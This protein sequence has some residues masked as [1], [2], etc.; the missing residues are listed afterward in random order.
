MMSETERNLCAVLYGKNDLRLVYSIASEITIR[1]IILF[2]FQEERKFLKKP[3]KGGVYYLSVNLSI[4]LSIYL[5]RS[6]Y[7]YSQLVCVVAMF[8][9]GLMVILGMHSF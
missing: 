7:Q 2:S 3:G 9:S 6:Y 4:Y 5:K 8:I 1:F